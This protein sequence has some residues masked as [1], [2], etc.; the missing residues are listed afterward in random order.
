VNQPVER[1]RYAKDR[2]TS[3]DVESACAWLF[4]QVSA[5]TVAK[6][7]RPLP[8]LIGRRDSSRAL[9]WCARMSVATGSRCAAQ[10]V[11][12]ETVALKGPM[13]PEVSTARTWK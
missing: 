7:G 2:R 9:S 12:A 4:S 6:P 13:L 3:D 1:T 8:A 11:R 10:L 5:R